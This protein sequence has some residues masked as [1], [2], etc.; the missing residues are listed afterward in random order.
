MKIILLS[1]T[2]FTV[3]SRVLSL[4]PVKIAVVYQGVG[5][6]TI[7]ANIHN[8]ENDAPLYTESLGSLTPNSS[9]IISFTLGINQANWQ[10]LTIQQIGT[11]VVVDVML[12]DNLYAQYRLDQ[13]II[14]QAQMS[15]MNVTDDGS[16]IPDE[17]TQSLGTDDV[18]WSDLYVGPSSVHIGQPSAEGAIK[19]DVTNQ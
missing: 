18:R 2:F 5:S 4:E 1:L 14:S 11:Y 8:Y 6:P 7:V 13:L 9:G 16:L 10:N 19:Y 12:N 17:P 15:L 3:V